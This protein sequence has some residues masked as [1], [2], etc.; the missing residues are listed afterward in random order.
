MVGVGSPCS[1][2]AG[3]VAPAPVS[4][5][6]APAHARRGG[7]RRS[8]ERRGAWVGSHQPSASL[9]AARAPAPLAAAEA[10]APVRHAAAPERLLTATLAPVAPASRRALLAASAILV[11]ANT[12]RRALGA[13][14]ARAP[15]RRVD[16]EDH[17]R[18]ARAAEARAARH[19]HRRPV[20][21]ARPARA[22][23]PARRRARPGVEALLLD[24]ALLGERRRARARDRR[25]RGQVDVRPPD[26]RRGAAARARTTRTSSRRAA[27]STAATTRA[28]GISRR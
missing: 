14:R 2:A 8:R 12:G 6:A 3:A 19:R 23:G 4:L 1:L 15:P 5:P 22:R 28:R 24:A 21:A 10:A 11:D 18:A 13:E 27:S 9:A 16:D 7:R 20:G 17:D 25:R 26:E